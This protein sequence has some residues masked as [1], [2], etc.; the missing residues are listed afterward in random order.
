[1]F[2]TPCL[3]EQLDVLQDDAEG[4]TQIRLVDLLMLMLSEGFA[5][6]DVVEGL[7]RL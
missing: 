7:I 2:S 1:M 4:A 6:G 5:V 3:G